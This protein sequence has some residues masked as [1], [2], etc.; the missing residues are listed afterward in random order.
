M[1]KKLG[2]I[3]LLSLFSICHLKAADLRSDS[4]DIIHTDISIDF[5]NFSSKQLI[6]K[7]VITYTPKINGLNYIQLDLLQLQ[8]DSVKMNGQLL[9][10]F[11]NDTTIS[12]T[13][14]IVNTGVLYSL[15][16]FY[17]GT[18]VQ[19][20]GDF[21]GFYW[22]NDY[23]FNIGVSFLADPH[24]FGKVWYPCF[25][26]FV[27]RST[28]SFHITTDSIRKAF[29]NGTI[30][31]ITTLPNNYKI[32]HWSLMQTIPSYLT[33]VA[34]SN[35]SVINDMYNA[36][37]GALPIQLA[38][39][40]TD[41]VR[42]R[43]SFAHLK[44][45]VAAFESYFGPYEFPKVGYCVVPFNAGAM[46][47]AT[48]ISY[49]QAA[50][51][52][53]T[54]L[55][56]LMAHELSHHWFGD[57]V[58]CDKAS[59][60][61]LNEGWA[62]YCEILFY[63]FLYGKETAINDLKKVQEDV[64]HFAHVDDGGYY[65]VSGVPTE[66]TYSNRHI[67]GKG[68]MVAHT[69]RAY[70]GDQQFFDC[71][72]N[73]LQFYKF[74][75]VN[76]IKLR[77]YLA[78]CSGKNLDNF[79]DNWV[80]EKG[81]PN[82]TFYS[83][84]VTQLGTNNFEVGIQIRQRLN[85]APTLYSNVPLEISFFDSLGNREIKT[86]TVSGECTDF[87]TFLNFNPVFI[88]IDFD[89]KIAD[90]TTENYKKIQ[91]QGTFDFGVGKMIVYATEGS[92][93]SLV[94]VQHHWVA[95]DAS[96]NTI[97]NLHLSDYRYWQVDGVW[98]ADFKANARITYNG[99]SN[100]SVG[101]LDKTF[102]TNKEDSLVVLYRPDAQS[103]WVYADSFKI[104]V[105]ASLTDKIG[106]AMIY[107][108]K[109]GEYSL[110]I[111]NA[112][113]PQNPGTP[114]T[115]FPLAVSESEVANIDFEV[116]PNPVNNQQINVVLEKQNYFTTCFMTNMF[117]EIVMEREIKNNQDNLTILLN[118]LPRGNYVISLKTKNGNIVS[119]KIL[120]SN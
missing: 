120:K 70:L 55:E 79:F 12:I 42:L 3:F 87:F 74:R 117:G 78:Q 47:H 44:D 22:T 104:F 72:K 25:D 21:G 83:K 60:M 4:I 39:A 36:Q 14:P 101:F 86:I 64:L 24:N 40:K 57:L 116:F 38:V 27:E 2:Y 96:K 67:Y 99:S 93:S 26:N 95:P 94:Q 82:F 111:F 118:G 37:N 50:V 6:G 89:E 51:D 56:N 75:D 54:N 18:P 97:P 16:V 33:M 52:G 11:Y 76:S 88:A 9:S 28:H 114:A 100:T 62:R 119:K 81:F 46:E 49:M 112:A 7:T 105:Q 19:P 35:Y 71:V 109:K 8:V 66:L 23:A 90:A 58:T 45:A 85:N 110:A 43:N 103:P 63:E 108:L 106:Y 29:C 31:S 113:L 20:S 32:W 115:C 17:K 15:T 68:A 34:V 92:D 59:E 41:S 80:F 48:S 102:I 91:G 13:T 77:D 30:D 69:L 73:Y 53:T 1:I 98:A 61:W 65:A 5:S 107:G 10:F 84:K